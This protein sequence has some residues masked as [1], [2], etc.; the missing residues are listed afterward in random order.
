MGLVM[1]ITTLVTTLKASLVKHATT[2]TKLVTR[3]MI[4]GSWT[5]IRT[6]ARRIFV[7]EKMSTA[8][9]ISGDRGEDNYGPNFHMRALCYDEEEGSTAAMDYTIRAIKDIEEKMFDFVNEE[10]T[11]DLH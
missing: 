7:E 3:S 5:K 10:D 6:S 8:T 4:V 11:D 1:A 9:L 2:V